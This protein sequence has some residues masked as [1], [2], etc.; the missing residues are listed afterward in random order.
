MHC[1]KITFEIFREKQKFCQ[2]LQFMPYGYEC[3]VVAMFFILALVN[4]WQ[5]RFFDQ[6]F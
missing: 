1:F 3:N 5:L 4:F 2:T 6:G